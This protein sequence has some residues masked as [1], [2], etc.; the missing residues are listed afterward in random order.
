MLAELNQIRQQPDNWANNMWPAN[1]ILDTYYDVINTK[2]EF[3][4]HLQ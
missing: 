1:H 3:L 4:I 2:L